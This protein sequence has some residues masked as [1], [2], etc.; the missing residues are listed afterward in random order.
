MTP[1]TFET[2]GE[3]SHFVVMKGRSPVVETAGHEAEAET[4]EGQQK[5][6]L[7]LLFADSR[8]IAAELRDRLVA[9]G[10]RVFLVSTGDQFT[11]LGFA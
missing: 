7:W 11:E 5:T 10:H 4:Q 1:L 8:G 2:E 9:M 6:Q 3:G